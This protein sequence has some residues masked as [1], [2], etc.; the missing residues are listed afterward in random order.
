M[1]HHFLPQSPFQFK[2]TLLK[3]ATAANIAFIYPGIQF[4]QIKLLE[5]PITQ[6]GNSFTGKTIT[7][8]P[9]VSNKQAD[10]G[11]TMKPMN[12]TQFNVSYMT[13]IR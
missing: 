4:L 13:A 5:G 8:T 10:I 3:C 2:S 6:Q 11:S 7:P 12:R 9:M 1:V